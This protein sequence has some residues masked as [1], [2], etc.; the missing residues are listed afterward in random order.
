MFSIILKLKTIHRRTHKKAALST[1]IYFKV[2]FSR[3]VTETKP[4]DS[5]FHNSPTV[6]DRISPRG[7]ICKN[8]F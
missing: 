6:N 2:S 5:N 7:L 8:G 4:H 3:K 1:V